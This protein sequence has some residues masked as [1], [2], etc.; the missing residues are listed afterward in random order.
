MDSQGGR[1]CVERVEVSTAVEED[2]R[3]KRDFMRKAVDWGIFLNFHH[4]N[5]IYNL[6]NI[7]LII[8]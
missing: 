4:Y 1:C 8:K 6:F 5:N 3:I 2:G 7:I